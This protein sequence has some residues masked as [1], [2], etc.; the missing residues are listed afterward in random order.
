MAFNF[1]K[2]LGRDLL[3]VIN[4]SVSPLRPYLRLKPTIDV[5]L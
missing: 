3:L 2:K 4:Q 1:I 5:T